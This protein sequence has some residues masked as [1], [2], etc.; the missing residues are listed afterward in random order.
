[1]R[2]RNSQHP[3][4]TLALLLAFVLIAASL[5]NGSRPARAAAFWS[6]PEGIVRGYPGITTYDVAVDT[7]GV[8]HVVFSQGDGNVYYLNNGSGAWKQPAQVAY[9]QE[10]YLIQDV[11]LLATED[12][13]L[14]LFYIEASGSDYQV[15]HMRGRDRSWSRERLA[16][17]PAGAVYSQG[18]FVD[19][20]GYIHYLLSGPVLGAEDYKGGF[21][22]WER[23]N[24]GAYEGKRAFTVDKMGVHHAVWP[25]PNAGK[26]EIVY[27]NDLSGSWV[28]VALA[29]LD[30][31]VLPRI[32][33]DKDLHVHVAWFDPA[34]GGH[35]FQ[36]SNAADGATFPAIA[37]DI[38]AGSTMTFNDSFSMVSDQAGNLS[39]AAPG[40][41]GGEESG[42]YCVTDESGRW[43]SPQL[44][45]P[46]LSGSH[47]PGLATRYLGTYVIY[48]W[49]EGEGLGY[50][51]G[52]PAGSTAP[53]PVSGGHCVIGAAQTAN[54]WYFAEGYTGTG[55]NGWLT[56]ANATDTTG[57]AEVTYILEGEVRQANYSIMAH[58]RTTIDL[59]R[60]IGPGKNVSIRVDSP[61]PITVE[62]PMYFA[63]PVPGGEDVWDGGHCVMGVNEPAKEW[64]FA[65][66]TTRPGF[67]EWLTIQN[68]DTT[69][70]ALITCEY[71][72][73]NGGSIT[74][75]YGVQPASRATIFVN[76]EVENAD[77]S[78]HLTSDVDIIC[79]RP[80]YFNYGG[81]WSGGHCVAGANAPLNTWY[82]AEGT[83]RTGFDEWLCV[84]NPAGIEADVD[85]QF[86]LDGGEIVTCTMN[87]PVHT[88]RT[89][90]VPEVVEPG[91]DASVVVACAETPI[92]VE[93]PMYFSLP[94][95]DGGPAWTGGHDV[96]G[97]QPG[98]FFFFA[99]GC[100]RPGFAE[101]LCLQNPGA[102][103][104]WVT[105]D[106]IPAGG[107]VTTGT[108]LLGPHSRAT[109]S[110]NLIAGSDKDVSMRVQ[111][112]RDIICERPMYFSYNL[113]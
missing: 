31:E 69:R 28:D 15:W 97:G 52:P 30:H 34:A 36:M 39:L 33:V 86:M 61:I 24:L 22:L 26:T 79:E 43:Q 58:A 75:T 4:G 96:L 32:A 46:G 90:H 98:K 25:R 82:F 3:R 16:D 9:S 42:L 23:L 5:A 70:T 55:F 57:T 89:L 7:S 80:M 8:V 56:L 101:W 81:A 27:E 35:I 77:V 104:A 53:G 111:S 20:A 85:F 107:N 88:R 87:V 108:Y 29:T 106:Y 18:S 74:K 38:T 60:E 63:Y 6:Q 71:M 17:Y 11:K 112:N 66:G 84:Q 48:D 49:P 19:A 50:L 10:S 110:V 91:R 73:A 40:F 76:S 62:R 12:G 59:V 67:N 83:T 44:M 105:V 41:A 99:E 95:P 102:E 13:N 47:R 93:R 37:Q 94:A 65:E 45:T 54:T 68:P 14:Q 72:R 1:M 51:F 103:N 78:M 113:Q 100:T 92:V 109:V 2:S 64:Y 21:G